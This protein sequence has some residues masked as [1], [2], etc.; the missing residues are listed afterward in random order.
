M[1]TARR[2]SEYGP[3]LKRDQDPSKLARMLAASKEFPDVGREKLLDGL[4]MQIL[5]AQENGEAGTAA[6]CFWLPPI[7][8]SST[9]TQPKRRSK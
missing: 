8:Q 1:R 9:S 5:H 4:A 6:P 2:T 3:L 7:K